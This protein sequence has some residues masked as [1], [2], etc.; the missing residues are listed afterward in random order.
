[1][2]ILTVMINQQVMDIM[3][4]T[5]QRI[6]DVLR[7]LKDN[8]KIYYQIE[9]IMVYSMRKKEYINQ[10]LTFQQAEVYTGDILILK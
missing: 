9:K 2:I 6:A 10:L 8:K 5:D 3:V 7:V 4:K 1:M